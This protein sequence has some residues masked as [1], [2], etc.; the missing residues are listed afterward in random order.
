LKKAAVSQS[1]FTTGGKEGD[2]TDEP[3]H[4]PVVKK[5]FFGGF[6]LTIIFFFIKL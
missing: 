2:K 4:Q 5:I 3:L 6:V 1:G